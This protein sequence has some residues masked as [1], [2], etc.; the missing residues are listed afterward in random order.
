MKGISLSITLT[1]IIL[2]FYVM[3]FYFMSR[4]DPKRQQDK[5]GWAWDYTLLTITMALGI[6]LQPIFLPGLGWDIKTVWGLVIQIIGGL[7]IMSSFML[8]IWARYHLRQFYVERVEVQADHIVIDT[9]PYALVRHPLITSFF[10]IAGGLFLLN[11]ALTTMFVLIYTIWDFTRSAKQEE[12]LLSETV[13]GYKT[14]MERT[15]R[16]L[17]HPWRKR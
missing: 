1:I 14:Y 11:P 4:Y 5:K 15:P 12:H 17:P 9:G 16:F 13:P 2:A 10:L 7:M 3:D 8:H 6:I